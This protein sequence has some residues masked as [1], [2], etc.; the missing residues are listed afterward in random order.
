MGQIKARS[1][2]KPRSM[3][4]P[5]PPVSLDHLET[6]LIGPIPG[7]DYHVPSFEEKNRSPPAVP[8]IALHLTGAFDIVLLFGNNQLKKISTPYGVL[9]TKII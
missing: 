8:P 5:P 6:K 1:S 2:G 9:V 7:P 4:P 3:P